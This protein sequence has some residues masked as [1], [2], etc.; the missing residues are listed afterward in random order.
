MSG[1]PRSSRQTGHGC[2]G[3]ALRKRWLC[4]SHA[5]LAFGAAV[6]LDGRDLYI[7]KFR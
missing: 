2:V 4:A 5:A 1:A 7:M 3:S 6:D